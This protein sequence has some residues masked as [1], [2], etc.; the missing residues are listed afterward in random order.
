MI[1]FLIFAG[2][3]L[4][5]FAGIVLFGTCQFRSSPDTVTALDFIGSSAGCLMIVAGA[6]FIVGV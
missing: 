5:V 3:P 1:D 4:L 2:P 6:S